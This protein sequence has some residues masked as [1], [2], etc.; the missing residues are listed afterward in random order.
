MKNNILFLMIL[1]LSTALFLRVEAT[2]GFYK[3]LFMDG[4]VGL[5]GMKTLPAADYLNYSWEFIALNSV[6]PQ[7]QIMIKNE[8]DDN[9]VLL[10][11]DGEPRFQLIFTNGG[12]SDEH[13]ESLGQEGR[14]RVRTFYYRGGSYTGAVEVLIFLHL[15][16]TATIKYGLDP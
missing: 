6:N 9:G 10:Y 2:E 13:G 12:M 11:P 5:N 16:K 7:N 14:E 1:S 4:G 15:T 8:N 3:D